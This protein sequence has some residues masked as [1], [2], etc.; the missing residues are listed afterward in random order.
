MWDRMELEPR[1]KFVVIHLG[2]RTVW[3]EADSLDERERFR[4]LTAYLE[5]RY[6]VRF[7]R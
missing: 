5:Q 7:N 2:N 1:Q 6:G 4:E 3:R